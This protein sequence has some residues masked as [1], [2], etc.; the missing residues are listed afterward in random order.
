M[1]ESLLSLTLA[2]VVLLG[3]PGPAPLA[4]AA[5]GGS[6]GIRSGLPFLAGILAGLAVAIILAAVG[7]A[8]LFES[9]PQTRLVVQILGGLYITYLAIKIATAPVAGSSDPSNPTA[10]SFVDGFLLNLLNPKAYAAFLAIFAQFLLPISSPSLAWLGTA[11]VCF[12]IAIIV[13]F[14]WLCFGGM[15]APL[16]GHPQLARPIRIAFALMMLGSVAWAYSQ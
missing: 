6:Y 14:L 10:P 2:T 7:L 15:L 13:D 11:I 12:I 9:F 4:L 3:S 8:A 16:F 5:T 1:L